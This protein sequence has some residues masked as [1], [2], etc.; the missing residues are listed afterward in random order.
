MINKIN[1]SISADIVEFQ[2]NKMFDEKYLKQQVGEFS[3]QYWMSLFYKRNTHKYN[4]ITSDTA[5]E[6]INNNQIDPKKTLL[7]HHSNDKKSNLMKYK[8]CIPFYIYCMESPLYAGKFYD[9]IDYYTEKF[10]YVEIFEGLKYLV[11]EKENKE[12]SNYLFPSY[13]L[14]EVLEYKNK[15][16]YL[17][18]VT[19]NKFLNLKTIN[20]IKKLDDFIL[21]IKKIKDLFLFNTDYSKKIDLKTKILHYE[22]YQ[23]LNYFINKKSIEIGGANW[24]YMKCI[25]IEFRENFAN[26]RNY[27]EIPKGQKVNFISKYKYCLCFENIRLEGYITEKILDSMKAMTI[28]I[29]HGASNIDKYIPS[30]CFIKLSDFQDYN[31]LNKY[32]KNMPQS[33]YELYLSNINAFFNNDKSN[34]NNLNYVINLENKI[35]KLL[36]MTF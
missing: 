26:F 16:K 18:I 1:I 24:D 27:Y 21:Y 9:N 8:G 11:N 22:K 33:E 5:L 6:K 23:A 14:S 29:Y 35:N 31:E 28:P 20:E 36:N 30:N 10:N 3:S 32:L 12:V 15:N 34:F 19:R 2:K 4:I 13:D 17:C 25:P 7:I